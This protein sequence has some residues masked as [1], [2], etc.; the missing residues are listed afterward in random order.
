MTADRP[1]RTVADAHVNVAAVGGQSACETDDFKMSFAR[2]AVWL[3]G[4]TQIVMRQTTR[5]RHE[6]SGF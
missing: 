4:K 5:A 2:A 3:I 1:S 6:P